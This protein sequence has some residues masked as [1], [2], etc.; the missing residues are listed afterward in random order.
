MIDWNRV[1]V[2]EY[3]MPDG[4]HL[5]RAQI[6]ARVELKVLDKTA[7]EL[8]G[9][10]NSMRAQVE[11]DAR[12]GLFNKIYGDLILPIK[13]LY[14]LAQTAGTPNNAMTEDTRK[15]LMR[16]ADEAAKFI[17]DAMQITGLTNPL[18]KKDFNHTIILPDKKDV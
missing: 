1:Q 15:E 2:Q 18:A 11:I 10:W 17:E 3:T 9:G 13:H 7:L 16:Q 6:M 12:R 8:G 5:L 14:R 4:S